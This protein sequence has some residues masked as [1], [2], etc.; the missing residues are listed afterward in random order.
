MLA[1]CT[2]ST[3]SVGITGNVGA[4]GNASPGTTNGVESPTV[5]A[6]D[7]FKQITDDQF[8]LRWRINGSSMN[9]ILR[10]PTTGW[11]GVG[12]G[13]TGTM[14][15]SDII[16]GYVKNGKATIVDAYGNEPNSHTNDT[17]LGGADQLT[18]KVGTKINGVTE[19]SFTMPLQSGDPDDVPLVE[20]HTYR[21]LLAHGPNGA[22]DLFTYHGRN[23]RI[24][25]NVTL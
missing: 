11:V 6:A 23:G 22:D 7:G 17:A 1:G 2:R 8:T 16:I 25:V 18:N 3:G 20:G 14:Q 5:H 21:V 10:Y 13:T 12:F 24:I 4:L 19:I 9:V 15:G